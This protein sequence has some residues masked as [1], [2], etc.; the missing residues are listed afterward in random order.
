[1]LVC[2]AITFMPLLICSIVE[3]VFEDIDD[4]I[5]ESKK[6]DYAVLYVDDSKT[7]NKI[8]RDL[9]SGEVIMNDFP[10]DTYKFKISK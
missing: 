2:P 4:F 3:E 7:I 5:Y 6:E 10:F 8:Q 9:K 1:M